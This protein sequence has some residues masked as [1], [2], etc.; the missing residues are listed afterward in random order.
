MTKHR[1]DPGR[2]ASEAER[3]RVRTIENAISTAAPGIAIDFEAARKRELER[4]TTTEPS[5]LWI[6]RERRRALEGR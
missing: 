5:A 6:E 1:T 4:V 3:D 2:T